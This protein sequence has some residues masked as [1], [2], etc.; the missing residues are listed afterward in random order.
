MPKPHITAITNFKGGSGKTVT[1]VNLACALAR[2]GYRVG[3]IDLDPQGNLTTG[4]A[5]DLAT[6]L[7]DGTLQPTISEALEA[8]RRGCAAAAI[9]QCGFSVEYAA[10][11]RVIG[12]AEDLTNRDNE[13]HIPGAYKRLAR[14]LDGAID[15]C[16]FALIDTGP[17]LG[18]LQQMALNAADT[19][20]IATLSEGDSIIGATRLTRFIAASMERLDNPGLRII[21]Y[22]PCSYDGRLGVHQRGVQTLRQ[23]DDVYAEIREEFVASPDYREGDRIPLDYPA[24]VWDPIPQRAAWKTAHENNGGMGDPV[25]TFGKEGQLIATSYDAASDRY[26]AAVGVAA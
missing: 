25:E 11:I 14:V 24:E 8:D 1:A 10:N 12:A 2:K 19:V 13:M 5:V 7:P 4:L 6:P 16:D 18:L 22:L 17:G 26:V 3:A 9:V 23:M 21:G 20:L 15:D